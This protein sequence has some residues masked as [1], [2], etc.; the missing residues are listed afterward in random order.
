MVADVVPEG[1]VALDHRLRC[2]HGF[3]RGI[4]QHLDVELL[5]R[6]IQAAYR[7]H[8]PVHHELLVEDGKLH[9]DAR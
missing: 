8:Q 2:V 4:I 9:G 7:F 5:A 3:V 1:G 6:I